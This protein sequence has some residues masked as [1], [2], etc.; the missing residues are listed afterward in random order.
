MK[1]EE[2]DQFSFHNLSE[3]DIKSLKILELITKKNITSRTEI[4]KITGINVV[5][6][7]NYINKYI[8][9]E[10]ITEKGFDVSTGGRKP[11]LVELNKDKNTIV[12]LDIG[13]DFIRAVSADIGLSITAKEKSPNPGGSA[14]EIVAVSRSLIEKILKKSGAVD[15][16]IRAIGIGANGDFFSTPGWKKDF[17]SGVEVFTGD[18]SSCAAFGEKELNKNIPDGDFL[19]IYSDI[20]YGVVVQDDGNSISSDESEYLRPWKESLGAVRLAKKDVARGIGTSI[21]ALADGKVENITEDIV[22]EAAGKKDEVALSIMRGVGMGLGLR[23]AYLI[24]LFG[25]KSVILGGGIEKAGDLVLKPIKNIVK[26]LSFRDRSGAVVIMPGSL[27]EDAVS[28][29]AA[30]LAAREIFLRAK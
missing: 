30:S 8:K 9:D 25:P 19:Y 10:L 24:N 14:K 29:G 6:I 1:T 28:A 11:E 5:S 13:D 12:G 22:I 21:V 18:R 3:K 15:S 27:G 4:S 2:A 17:H 16:S 20:G 23:I 7:S 26:K